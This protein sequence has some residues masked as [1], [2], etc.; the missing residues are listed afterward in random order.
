MEPPP[1]A[2]SPAHSRRNVG[3]ERA[4][5][6]PR[7]RARRRAAPVARRRDR[8]AGARADPAADRRLRRRR[9]PAAYL[10]AERIDAVDRRDPS[11]R[12]ANV[13]QRA[14]RG[15]RDRDAARRLHPPAVGAAG[16][17][18]LDRGRDDGR[19]GRGARDAS[20]KTVFLTQ[21]RL[22]LAAF[23][24]APQ[25]R[26]IVRAIDRPAEIDALPDCRLI[27]G[28]RP[29]RARRRARADAAT[30][31]S[32]RSSPRTAAARDLRQDRGGADAR[33]QRRHGAAA[34]GA[35]GRDAARRSTP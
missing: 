17:R 28:A 21:G 16:G 13:G 8:E 33:R 27:L 23:A 26:Y 12:R 14:R 15:A 22:Q 30:S 19:C 4:R 24:K 11:L 20:G 25:H 3:S 29:V 5:A 2:P 18:P 34:E 6:P 31:G 7:R 32:R 9:G 35:G 10:K 1:E